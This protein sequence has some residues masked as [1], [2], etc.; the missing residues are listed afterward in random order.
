MVKGTRIKSNN[1][2]QSLIQSANKP[3]VDMDA[4]RSGFSE[5]VPKPLSI[6]VLTRLIET[7]LSNGESD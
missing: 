2:N 3:Y 6:E 7:Y 4:A 5:I 1:L